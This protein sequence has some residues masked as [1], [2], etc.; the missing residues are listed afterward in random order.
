MLCEISVKLHYKNCNLVT[1]SVGSTS[2]EKYNSHGLTMKA[3][4]MFSEQFTSYKDQGKFVWF[5]FVNEARYG[6]IAKNQF[7]FYNLGISN[8]CR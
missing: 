3:K 4:E 2:F 8:F 5:T 6:G 7:A 1:F